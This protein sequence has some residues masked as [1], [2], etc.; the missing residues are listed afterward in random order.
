M[1]SVLLGACP[2]MTFRT[3][4]TASLASLFAFAV[5]A[6]GCDPAGKQGQLGEGG[7]GGQA[8]SGQNDAGSGSGMGGDEIGFTDPGS[9]TGGAGFEACATASETATTLPLNMFIAIDRSG[10]MS[11]NNKWQNAK[12]AFVSFF[13]SPENTDPNAKISVALRFW[14]DGQCTENTCSIDACSQ[15]Q[16]ALGPLADPNQVNSLVNL[17]NSKNPNGN[18]P[19]EAALGGAA[20]WGI[21]NAQLGEGGTATVIVFVTDGEPNGCN[22]NIDVIASYAENA[23]STAQVPTFAV[24]LAGS[25]E[26]Q[27]T[28]IAVAGNTTKP[29]LIGNGNAQA[30]LTAALKEIQKATLACVFAM[31]EAQ[32]SDP[33]D[34]KLVNISYTPTGASAQ[35][36]LQVSDES[37]CDAAGGWGWYYDNPADPKVIQLC[38]P[39]CDSVQKDENGKIEIILGCETKPA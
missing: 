22:E 15:P 1:H 11:D 32:G 6:T 28:K 13:Q 35:T 34:P 14:P 5:V 36:I 9:G 19:M 37:G 16:V 29:F 30:D 7:S 21:E 33:I 10:S 24:G 39:L 25:N 8:G 26:G 23:Y 4:S 17:Y 27:M 31:P 12:A 20:K 18:T 2:P 3:F 38:A